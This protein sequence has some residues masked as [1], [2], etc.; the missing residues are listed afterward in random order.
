[1]KT[2]N[3]ITIL[4]LFLFL[5]VAYLILSGLLPLNSERKNVVTI[6][7]YSNLSPDIFY[8]PQPVELEFMTE[9]EKNMLNIAVLPTEKIQVVKR[10]QI[11]NSM[12]YRI[13]RSDSDILT[14]Y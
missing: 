9:E 14:E 3:I 1:M 2:K 6:S 11:G 5:V 13:I 8:K 10:D 4:I 7:E 12:V